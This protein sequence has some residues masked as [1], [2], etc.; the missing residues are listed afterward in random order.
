M[1]RPLGRTRILGQ[2]VDDRLRQGVERPPS[3]GDPLP[4]GDVPS[5][6]R[7]PPVGPQ[8]TETRSDVRRTVARGLHRSPSGV[9]VAG[10]V[11]PTF[12]TD[13]PSPFNPGHPPQG[14]TLDLQA[15]VR[16]PACH[17]ERCMTE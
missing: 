4:P 11:G 10:P 5:E 7:P 8:G 12:W 14:V 17:I 9:V 16:V 2:G 15:Q 1:S 6:E 3:G 13:L